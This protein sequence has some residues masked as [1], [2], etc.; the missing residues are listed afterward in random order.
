MPG[1]LSVVASGE[2]VLVV[3]AGAMAIEHARVL[4]ALGHPIQ[5]FGRGAESARRFA[6]ATGV[7]PTTGPLEEQLTRMTVV[8]AAA[9]VAVNAMH[10]AAVTAVVARAGIAKILVEKP[11][12]L[13][14]F[15]VESLVTVARETSADIRIGYNRRYL[16]SVRIARQVIA[17]D[18]GPLSA[19]LDF[20]EPSRRI[21]KLAKPQRE[22][23][24]WFFGNSTHVVDLAFHLA[25]ECTEAEAQVTGAVDWHPAGGVFAGRGRTRAGAL[26]SWH[27]NWV[28]PGRWGVQVV[29]ERRRLILQ[30][31]ERLRAQ[32]HE[33][34][35]EHDVDLDLE[36]DAAFKPGLVRQ[37]RAFLYGE[38]DSWLPD[39]FDQ[40]R[41][42][43][44]YEVIRSGGSMTSQE[45]A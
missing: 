3:G 34:F 20:S 11:G 7:T 38:S 30:P 25:G 1:Q 45:G 35:E 26:V 8:P 37:A 5:V 40:A 14:S 19:V 31:L 12:A 22:L 4:A 18:G 29:T 2:P 9:V 32:D 10:L 36:L 13:D 24:T 16:E 44:L 39:V 43:P 15:E 33:G 28:G 42:W 6:G 23:E 27:A 21:A 41:V 17:D